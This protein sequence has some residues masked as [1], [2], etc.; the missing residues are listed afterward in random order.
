MLNSNLV[1]RV[2]GSSVVIAFVGGLLC[3]MGLP[4]QAQQTSS[5]A[6][7]ELEE[8]VVT[9]ERRS[10]DIQKT[11]IAIDVVSGDELSDRGISSGDQIADLVPGIKI[12]H[13]RGGTSVFVRGIGN[14]ASNPYADP[15]V[16]FN[17][18]GVAM[19]LPSGANGLL[20]DMARLEVLKGPQGTL[21]GRNATA[22]A[23][24]VISNDPTNEFGGA[25][26]VRVG[27]YAQ[28]QT[29]GMINI[30]LNEQLAV[31]AA[32]QT[33]RHGGYLSDGLDDADDYAGRVKLLWKPGDNLSILLGGDYSHQGGRGG[34]R[35]PLIRST[36]AYYWPTTL[37]HGDEWT[38]QDSFP[39]P[40]GGSTQLIPADA[41]V[42]NNN[43]GAW[44]Q[45]DWNLGFGSLTILPA[46]RESK[47]DW[48]DADNGFGF[49]QFI[50]DRA[51]TIEMR[52]ASN[53]EPAQRLKWIVG[54]YALNEDLPNL[55]VVQQ[56]YPVV[57]SSEA[58]LF[59][60]TGTPYDHTE[61]YAAF[62]QATYSIVDAFR[63]TAGGRY[64][65]DSK[66][67]SGYTTNDVLPGVSNTFQEYWAV[68]NNKITWKLGFDADVGPA[69]MLY[70]NVSTGYKA[71]GFGA[72]PTPGLTPGLTVDPA[73]VPL[74]TYKPEELL[75]YDL[76]IKNTFL[77]RRL[78][79]NAEI[80]YW[81]YKNQQVQSIFLFPLP[82]LPPV[83]VPSVV[84]AG[85]G[86]DKGVDLDATYLLTEHDKVNASVEYLNTKYTSFSY[87]FIFVNNPVI[88]DGKPFINSPTWSGNLGYEHDWVVGSGG[89]V[90][91][92]LDAHLTG[93]YW[94][95][96]NYGPH[97]DEQAGY[98]KTDI[99]L[100]YAAADDRW[101]VDFWVKN[102][103]NVA[104]KVYTGGAVPGSATAPA[105]QGPD[106]Q[107]LFWAS[108]QPPRTMG[109]TLGAKF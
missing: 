64:T 61:S 25:A 87:P 65:R 74:L 79:L 84:N 56:S 91:A 5:T 106:G 20:F 109:V 40:A 90:K 70:G 21:Y 48:N 98:S 45:I 53:D 96:Y 59:Q 23:V 89:T 55:V 76:G 99:K 52:L 24:N 105:P 37:G 11:P 33:D 29:N 71:G 44:A 30:P 10:A 14:S 2:G 58:E 39:S 49:Q 103:E 95:G 54:A 6:G 4:A 43:W 75:A 67:E 62:A 81:I 47:Q 88:N 86:I 18:D 63:L 7:I 51:K 36:G 1:V 41:H 8:I 12:M 94:T 17:V 100:G 35:V 77:D 66:H 107:G 83:I 85:K 16:S 32:F 46:Y 9:A 80:F 15:D 27:D 78:Q 92:S 108:I 82:A 34:Q 3:T 42:I 57:G 97:T 72:G 13:E 31:R 102:I 28:F 68:K 104:V 101:Y 69:S 19:T 93:R 50:N 22:G 38:M 73:L 60:T 26:E